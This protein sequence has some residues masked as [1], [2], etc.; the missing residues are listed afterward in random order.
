[1]GER[2]ST[3]AAGPG[4]VGPAAVSVNTATP[5]AAPIQA[6]R[7]RGRTDER[8]IGTLGRGLYGRH[9]RPPGINVLPRNAENTKASRTAD[10]RDVTTRGIAVLAVL[11]V[12]PGCGTDEPTACE[13]FEDRK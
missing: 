9:G 1:M 5:H 7:T 8:L 10:T 13:G 12:S 6:Q 2:S 4:P 11:A 3:H